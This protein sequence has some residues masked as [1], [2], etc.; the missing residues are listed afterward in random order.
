[1]CWASYFC[2]AGW[3]TLGSCYQMWAQKW[4][5]RRRRPW[6]T[7]DF[8]IFLKWDF[9]FVGSAEKALKDAIEMGPQMATAT[10]ETLTDNW[11]IQDVATKLFVFAC[12]AETHWTLFSKLSLKIA[13][14]TTAATM[15]ARW[16]IQN[17]CPYS[18]ERAEDMS[19]KKRTQWKNPGVGFIMFLDSRVYS[20]QE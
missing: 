1:M 2:V 18:V 6:R 4:R 11:L 5:R 10:A 13:T 14:V 19:P 8:L 3:K 17:L 15:I 9:V 20:R 16:Y 12:S 7:D